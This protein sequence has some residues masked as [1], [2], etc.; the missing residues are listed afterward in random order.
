MKRHEP[1]NNGVPFKDKI[2][3]QFRHNKPE[4]IKLATENFL[5]FLLTTELII[6]YIMRFTKTS[7]KWQTPLR[8]LEG[9]D[10]ITSLKM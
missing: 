1:S 3:N 9:I 8:N 6:L 7:L 5:K 2:Y 4:I 10:T